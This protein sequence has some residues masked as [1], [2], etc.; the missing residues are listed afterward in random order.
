M[1]V[2]L[3]AKLLAMTA[4]GWDHHTYQEVWPWVM[5]KQLWWAAQ[6]ELTHAWQIFLEDCVKEFSHQC[7]NQVGLL[8]DQG[9]IACLNFHLPQ[10]Q[11]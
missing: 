8:D 6:Q 5:E 2:E 7:E 11:L 10:K 1:N 3:E 9:A 4:M